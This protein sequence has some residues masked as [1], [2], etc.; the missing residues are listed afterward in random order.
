MLQTIREVEKNMVFEEF[1]GRAGYIMSGTVRRFERSDVIVDLGR[2]EGVMPSRERV[3]TE[4][5][6]PGDRIRAYILSV[7]NA[8]HGPE[9]ILSRSHLDFVKKWFELED[10][11]LA[12]TSVEIVGVA[13]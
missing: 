12:D 2:I 7:T 6:Q 11:A 3:P 13:R 10:T 4:E 1:K 9:I 8:A 5:Y